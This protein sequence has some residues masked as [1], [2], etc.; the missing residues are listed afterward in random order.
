MPKVVT[1]LTDTEIKNAKP[2]NKDYQLTDGH[3]LLLL[4]KIGGAK[5]W[6]FGYINPID[7][8]RKQISF[9]TYPVV[10]LSDAR[11]KRDEARKKVAQGIDPSGERKE[12]KAEIKQETKGQFHLVAHNWFKIMETKTAT[13]THIKRVKAFER[14]I[15][16]TFCKYDSDHQIISSKNIQDIEHDELLNCIRTKEATAPETAHRLLADCSRLWL[17]AVS[18]KYAKF[19]IT[20]NISR[21]SLAEKPKVKHIAKI[22]NEKLLGELLR[23]IDNYTG[24]PITKNAL[25]LVSILPYRRE[26][27]AQLKWEYVDWDNEVITLPRIIMKNRDQN[28]PDFTLP[29]P[30]QAIEILKDTHKITGWGEWIFHGIDNSNTHISLETCNKALRLIGFDDEASGRKQTIH[31]F[32]GTFRSLANTHHRQHKAS[33]ETKEAVLDHHTGDVTV[34]SYDHDADY[35]G[36]IQKLLTWWADFLD[37]TRKKK[38]DAE[39]PYTLKTTA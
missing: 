36:Q 24:H 16:P 37:E 29:L 32:R 23:A 31:S 35:T 6:R 27:L 33:F 14:D 10:S 13:K 22:T 38:E 12:A 25:K 18:E 9:G 3:G 4:V 19:N 2:K 21:E 28:I 34:K 26:R 17:H 15:F 1:P 8:K 20:A 7:K 39:N 5:W 11:Q 30:K